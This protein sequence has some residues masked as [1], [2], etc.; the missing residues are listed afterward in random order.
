[1]G[2]YR[3]WQLLKVLNVHKSGSPTNQLNR[4]KTIIDMWQIAI[5]E[6]KDTIVLMDDN[7][8]SN[9]NSSHH[10]QFKVKHLDELL[11]EHIN[12]NNIT[13]HNKKNTRF[14]RNKQPS[15]LDHIYSNCSDKIVNVQTHTNTFSD[16]AIIT[17]EY[18]S[19]RLIYHPKF[20]KIRNNKL[21]NKSTLSQHVKQSHLLNSFFSYDDPDIVADI[22]QL[23]LNSIIDSIVP[24]KI[25]Q[26]RKDYIP[27]YNHNI[28][29]S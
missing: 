20:I 18:C 25:V 5:G 12:H 14:A 9:I 29:K 13:V 2:G 26:Y 3:Q 21:L 28:L 4:W 17:A 23:E 22:L 10:K 27:Y 8:D 1:M 11:K 15:C 7:I 16:H 6:G 19:I 24:S